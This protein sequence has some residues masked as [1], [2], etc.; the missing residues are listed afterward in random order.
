MAPKHAEPD[1]RDQVSLTIEAPP[2]RLYDIVADIAQ[3]GRLSPECTGGTWLDKATGPAPGARFKGTNKRGRARWSTSNTVVAAEPGREFAFDT[4]QSGFRWRYRFES[5][6]EATVVT[7]SREQFAKRPLSARVFTKL[8]LGGVDGHDDEMR[9]G[10]MD[11]LARLKA[12]A[13]QPDGGSG[14]GG[15]RRR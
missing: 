5:D 8:L 2:D 3:M 1:P 15:G 10:M 9:T 12:V 7:E 6:G 13:E 14:R 11:T 4:K